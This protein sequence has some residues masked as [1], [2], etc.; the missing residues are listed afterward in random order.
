V[1]ERLQATFC[2]E[3]GSQRRDRLFSPLLAGDFLKSQ[4]PVAAVS[5][6]ALESMDFVFDLPN[7][8]EQTARF[9]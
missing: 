1:P 7:L 2:S 3:R 9:F 6:L 8:L 5:W 4:K